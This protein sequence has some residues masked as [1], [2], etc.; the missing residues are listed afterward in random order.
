MLLKSFIAE[1]ASHN[2]RL[3]IASSEVSPGNFANSLPSIK[4]PSSTTSADGSEGANA[5]DLKIAWRY[6]HSQPNQPQSQHDAEQPTF[7]FSKKVSVE[8]LGGK[9]LVLSKCYSDEE[10]SPFLL[11]QCHSPTA[12]NRILKE[13]LEVVNDLEL[14]GGPPPK[15]VARIGICHCESEVLSDT[16]F[17]LQLRSIVQHTNSCAVI[18]VSDMP[19]PVN[20]VNT[21]RLV[22]AEHY[23]DLVISL[24]SI[25]D[26]KRRNDL[27]GIDGICSIRKAASN[28]TLKVFEPPKDIGF[29]FKKKRLMFHV[30][31][32]KLIAK[33]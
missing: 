3:Y 28:S 25:V 8:E 15:N 10:E 12:G 16:S 21:E 24:S 23:A 30:S 1:G 5:A 9:N 6:A 27:G 11:S 18:S 4:K 26:Q 7:D 19:Y 22:T 29:L 20:K 33:F 17:L 32:R 13:I 2:H 31:F 14:E